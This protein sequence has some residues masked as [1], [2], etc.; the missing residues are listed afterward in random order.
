MAQGCQ[1]GRPIGLCMSPTVSRVASVLGAM[2]IS[3]PYVPIDPHFPDS[4]IRSMMD[5]AAAVHV[6]VDDVT[7]DRFASMPYEP[8]HASTYSSYGSEESPGPAVIGPSASD[9]AYIIYTS[10]STGDPKGVAV[11]HG[12]VSHLLDAFDGVLPPPRDR[13]AECWLAAANICFDMSVMDMFWPLSRGI[14][15][16]VAEMDSLAGKSDAGAQFL[17]TVLTSGR[18]TH[19]EATP[20]LVQLMLR[21]PALAAA[22][23]GLRV[24]IMGGEIVQPELAAALRPIPHV[25]NG[26]GPTEAT[27]YTTMHECSDEDLEYVP[28]GR[29]L[30]GV[31]LRVVDDT[32][33]DCPPGVPGELLIGGLGVAGGYVNDEELTARKF[34]VS[35]DGRRWYRTGDVVN[36]DADSTVRYRGRIDSQVKVRGF[37]VELGEIEAAM[38]AVPGV[39]EAAVFPIRDASARVTGL[40]AAVKSTAAGVSEAAVVAAISGVLPYYAVP[41]TV[42][43]VPELPIGISGKLDRKALERQLSEPVPVP[44]PV[45]AA[46][47]GYERIV[48][49]AWSSVLGTDVDADAK[50][51]EVGGNSVL[52]G[53]V[54][55]RLREAFPDAD[56][57]L[58]DMYRHP[59]IAAMA[60]RLRAGSPTQHEVTTPSSSG[61]LGAAERRRLARRAR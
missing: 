57:H 48:A 18:I 47:T 19:F 53:S 56:L 26:Y 59:T 21:D 38:R 7:A 52:L 12:S 13:S 40:T 2:G 60:E 44:R 10:G 6:I 42:R 32:G 41:H 24:L 33:Q 61:R 39:D 25:F 36:M 55:A 31:D 30:P 54:F 14:P 16:V 15:I 1:P 22:L 35:A 5:A 17:T 23:R 28:I 8:V 58:V 43:I 20:S 37:R 3:S 51:F 45:M 46:G 27:V 9:L 11:E 34:P 50:F 29:P 49:D 4:R